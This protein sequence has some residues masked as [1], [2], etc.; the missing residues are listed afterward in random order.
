MYP[1]CNYL[2]P[3][4]SFLSIAQVLS[5]IIGSAVYIPLYILSLNYALPRHHSSGA[6]FLL[7]AFVYVAT[8]PLMW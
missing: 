2:G 7:M 4:L 8:I 5:M 6:V 1:E 3:L